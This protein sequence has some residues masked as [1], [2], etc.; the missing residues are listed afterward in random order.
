M[1]GHGGKREGAG[2]KPGSTS[3]STVYLRELAMGH[4][5]D[6]I[7]TLVNLMSDAE[8]PAA[9]RVSAS[10]ELLERGFGKPSNTI[11]MTLKTP[12]SAMS[13]KEA[14]ETITDQVTES[15]ISVDDGAKLTSMIEA[16]IR[17]IEV[18]ELDERQTKLEGK[19]R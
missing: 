11:Q 19:K 13:P 18:A 15:A 10:K 6:A 2:R 7:A 3:L 5:D 12:L 1:S 14:L 9:A 8:T 17:A 4:A 16:R